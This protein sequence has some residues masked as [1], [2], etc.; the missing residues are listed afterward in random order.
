MSQWP[1]LQSRRNFVEEIQFL[2]V[3]GGFTQTC[4]SKIKSDLKTAGL[5]LWAFLLMLTGGSSEQPV[6]AFQ[7]RACS[8]PRF[9][10]SSISLVTRS[11][12]LQTRGHSSALSWRNRASG[13]FLSSPSD[14]ELNKKIPALPSG[15]CF[16]VLHNCNKSR[17]KSA[18][19]PS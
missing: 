4:V 2:D 8:H 11:S 19:T 14:D 12:C 1:T 15:G 13:I 6:D 7:P 16:S 17:K 10:F 5:R 3:S 9:Y 18:P